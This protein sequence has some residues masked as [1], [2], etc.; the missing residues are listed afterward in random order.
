M[1]EA[2]KALHG[3]NILYF[4]QEMFSF[5]HEQPLSTNDHGSKSTYR[6][7]THFVAYHRGDGEGAGGGGNDI[8]VNI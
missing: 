6:R 2:H 3:Y 7:N 5:H 8:V 1:V 4:F